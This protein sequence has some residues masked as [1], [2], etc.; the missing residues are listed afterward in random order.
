MNDSID[1]QAE[2]VINVIFLG[3][4]VKFCAK[5][6]RNWKIFAVSVFLFAM[7]QNLQSIVVHNLI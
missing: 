2:L 3:K 4:I 7:V 5:I 6:A 1:C